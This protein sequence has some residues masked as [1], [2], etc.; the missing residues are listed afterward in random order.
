MFFRRRRRRRSGSMLLTLLVAGGAMYY[1]GAG[2]WL[3][4]RIE[5]LPGACFQGMPGQ[6]AVCGGVEK[7]STFTVNAATAIG[8]ALDKVTGRNGGGFSGASLS[9]FG[10]GMPG[11][12]PSGG[13]LNLS[14]GL[15]LPDWSHVN[16]QALSQQFSGG[17]STA[18]LMQQGPSIALGSS[19]SMSDRLRGAVERFS[20][21]SQYSN[22]GSVN[23]SPQKALSWHQQ[24]A[25]FGDFGFGSQLALGNAYSQGFGT[26][27]DAGK[28]TAYLQQ[29]LKS[30]DG[31]NASSDPSAQ[32]YLRSFGASPEAMRNEIVNQI[33]A[34]QP[35]R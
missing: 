5:Q 30:L 25:Q 34:I 12:G 3:T 4:G 17:R 24:G 27:A 11:S 20:L 10:G 1:T 28:A 6:F 2:A 26:D 32:N 14:G 23:Y 35:K 19:N 15:R 29:A 21:G 8:A 7:V 9:G 31:L 22:P 33:R 16:L 13:S 18:Q